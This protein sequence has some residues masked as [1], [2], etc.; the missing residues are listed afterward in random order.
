MR[1]AWNLVILGAQ[2]LK[3]DWA[4]IFKSNQHVLT[5]TEQKQ[6]QEKEFVLMKNN[7]IS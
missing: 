5:W 1:L 6:Y 4:Q 2:E 3:N 7:T